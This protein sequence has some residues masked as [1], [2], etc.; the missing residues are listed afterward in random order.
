VGVNHS[1]GREPRSS[2]LLSPQYSAD[3]PILAI[4]NKKLVGA[5]DKSRLPTLITNNEIIS[6]MKL[7]N[8]K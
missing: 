3:T 4:Q 5:I 6:T 2:L 1:L 7:K 8:R